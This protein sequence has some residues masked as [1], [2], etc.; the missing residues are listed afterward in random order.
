MSRRE[1]AQV[2]TSAALAGGARPVLADEP[3]RDIGSRLELF[4]DD[5]LIERLEGARLMLHSPAPREVALSFNDV[6]WEGATSGYVTVLRDGGTYRLYY[7]GKPGNSPDGSE[8]EVT[9]YAESADG[10]LWRRP[11]LRLFEVKGTRDNNVIL[12]SA[13]APA[14]HNFAPF[15]DTR[16]G[17]AQSE[18]FKGLGG[19]FDSGEGRITSGGLLGFVAADGIHW[20]KIRAAAVIDRTSHPLYT[21]TTQSPAFW[22]EREGCYVCYVR[23]WKGQPPFREGWPG[24]IRWIGRI[25]S[26]DFL[27]WSRVVPLDL[28]QVPD[29]HH[30]TN[31]IQPYFRAPH[32]YIA[33]PF[34]FR[35]ERKVVPEH[36]YP[37]V[38]DGLFMTSR[39]GIHWDRRFMEAFVRPG[40]E[41]ENW[42]ERN[43]G[44]ACGILPT[45]PDEI[46]VYWQEHVR[47][48]TARLR[49]GALRLDGFVSVNAGYGGGS[50][51]SKPL[52]F[53]GKELVLNYATSAAGSVRA[54][55]LDASGRPI[56]GHR[57]EESREMYGDEIEAVVSW[58]GGSSVAAW[59]GRPVR[60]RLALTDAD[61]YSL[62]FRA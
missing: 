25:T 17:V 10:I 30:Y 47:H 39:D 57:L 56:P 61:V 12:S 54:E 52:R 27:R 44:L 58:R 48:P 8:D 18:R 22:S 15:I 62:R 45:A 26:P 14:P 19:L 6:P 21:D 59:A 46:S 36:P 51:L 16:P 33:L 43:I 31:Q 29:E 38:S 50:L 1:F 20:R 7:R 28:G 13:E 32:I 49:R 5:W 40:R 2:A 24:R 23:T 9:C 37:G 41:R 3:V 11:N 34:R 35:P 55:L 4:V 60:L 53:A 42:T